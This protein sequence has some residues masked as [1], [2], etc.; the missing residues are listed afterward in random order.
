MPLLYIEGVYIIQRGPSFVRHEALRQIEI[1][2]NT[3]NST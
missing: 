1:L 3:S 2:R